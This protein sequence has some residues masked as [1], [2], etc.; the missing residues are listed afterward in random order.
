MGLD[1]D[2][3]I[4]GFRLVSSSIMSLEFR[5]SKHARSRNSNRYGPLGVEDG[6]DPSIPDGS[7][8]NTLT[9]SAKK[10]SLVDQAP[11]W[12]STE[13]SLVYVGVINSI[14]VCLQLVVAA[15]TGSLAMVGTLLLVQA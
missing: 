11:G 9:S 7:D 6:A 10:R 1:Q 14:Y 12:S 4:T 13:Q 2:P 5:A 8:P 3:T 15:Q